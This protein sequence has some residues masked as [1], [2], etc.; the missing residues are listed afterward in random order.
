M[1][2]SSLHIHGMHGKQFYMTLAK[3]SFTFSNS[4]KNIVSA[5]HR[6]VILVLNPMQ[7]VCKAL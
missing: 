3:M 4:N 7:W 5:A 2:S 1:T 6:Y